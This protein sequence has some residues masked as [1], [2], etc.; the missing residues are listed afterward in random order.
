[1]NLAGKF[2]ESGINDAQKDKQTILIYLI[3]KHN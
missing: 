2:G 1:M 3:Q